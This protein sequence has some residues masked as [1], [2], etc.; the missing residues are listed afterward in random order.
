MCR[1]ERYYRMPRLRITKSDSSIANAS[2]HSDEVLYD[3]ERTRVFRSHLPDG[4]GTIICK[5]LLGP[6]ALQRL[7]HERKILERLGNI[8]GV[9]HL[10]PVQPVDSIALPDTRFTP[11]AEVVRYERMD[12]HVLLRGALHLTETIAAM[13][14]AGV[15]HKDINPTNILFSDADARFVLID[16]DLATTFLEE[17]PGFVPANEIAGTLAYLSPEQ[18]GRTGRSVDPRTDLYSLGVTLYQLATGQLPFEHDDPLQLIHDHLARTPVAPENYRELHIPPGLSDII[19]RLMEKEPDQRYQSAE[20]LAHD[21]ARLDGLLRQGASTRFALGERDFPLR[22]SPP[23]HLVGRDA[24][25]TALENAFN[26]T[27]RGSNSVLVTGAPGVGKSALTNELRTL[28]ATRGGWFVSGKFDQYRSDAGSGAVTQAFDALGQ[29]LLAEP[30]VRLTAERER[31]LQALGPNAGLIAAT[32]PTFALVLGIE[33]N[34]VVDDAASIGPRIACAALDALCAISSP[35]RPLVMVLDDLQW[36][37]AG[38]LGFIDAVLT[39]K[40][41]RDLLLVGTYRDTEVDATHPLTAMLARWQ[42]LNVAPQILQLANL[43]QNDLSTLLGEMLRLPPTESGQ[44]ARAIA[45]RTGGNPYDTVEL[46]NALRR[47]GVLIAG[48][49][50]W[51]W[52]DTNIQQH[53]GQGEVIDLLEVR[54]ARLPCE[55][56]ALLVVM[57]CLGGEVKLDLLQA[58]SG[59]GSAALEEHMT[60]AL[61]DGLLVM[62]RQGSVLRFRHDRVQQAAHTGL[63]AGRGRDLRFVLARRLALLPAFAVNAAELYLA[64]VDEIVD[65]AERRRAIELFEATA[66]QARLIADHATAERYLAAALTLLTRI[67]TTTDEPLFIRMETARHAAL[68]SLGRLAEADAI[69]CSLENRCRDPL[70]LAEAISLQVC[71]LTNRGQP[72]DAVNLGLALLKQLGLDVPNEDAFGVSVARQLEEFYAWADVDLDAET[73]QR[74][75]TSDRRV[76]AIVGLINKLMPPT[77]FCDHT[78][79]AWLFFETRRLWSSAGPSAA[80]IGILSHAVFVTVGAR[81]DYRTGYRLMQH[82]LAVG[83][84]LGYGVELSQGRFLSALCGHLF[85]P[86]EE[87]IRQAQLAREGLLA[88]GDIQNACFTYYASIPAVFECA[89]TL[90]AFGAEVE[91][92]LA[93]SARTGNDQTTEAFV[94]YRQ[95]LRAL[96]GETA[97]PGSLNDAVFDED[98]HLAVIA[99]NPAAGANFHEA[100][101]LA[102]MIFGDLDSLTKHAA[103]ALPLLKYTETTCATLL[104]H[105]LQGLALA[106]RAQVAAPPE[107]AALLKELDTCRDWLAE[108]ATDASSFPQLLHWLAA[109]RA[110]ANGDVLDAIA[111]FDAAII[112][113]ESKQRICQRALIVERAAL[114]H[115]THGT[116]HLGRTLMIQARHHYHG[117]GAAGKVRQLE[118]RYGFV[119]SIPD[120]RRKMESSSSSSGV[121]SDGIDLLGVL[122]ASQ[123]LSSETDLARLKD[124]VIELMGTLTGATQVQ[125]VLWQDEP[126]GWF[127][128]STAD[129]AATPIEEASTRNLLPLSVFRYVERTRNALLLDDA[130]RDDRF[131]RDAYFNGIEHCSLLAIPILSQGVTCAV[132]VMENRLSRSAFPAS[133]LEVVKLIAGQL[134]VSIDNARLYDSLERKV[135]QRT[136]ALNAANLRLETLSITDPLT[137]LANRRRFDELIQAEWQRAIRPKT[138]L[139]VAMVDIDQFKLYNDHYGHLGGDQCLQRVATALGQSVR[140]TDLVARYGGEEFVLIMPATDEAGA[141]IVAQRARAAVEALRTPHIKSTTGIVTIS[142]GVAATVP[143]TDTIPDQLIESADAALYDAKKSGRNRVV[144]A[145]S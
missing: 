40:R 131:C 117:W 118:Q 44:L 120:R 52:N 90:T 88:S 31:L 1:S 46:V 95:L 106:Q 101:A 19:L 127:L 80:M 65:T 110:W 5:Q 112:A 43:P 121:T 128:L 73:V 139:A 129:T 67:A 74:S 54:I 13:H 63:D 21:L 130:L 34:A 38:A 53:V 70:D 32:H 26:Q 48:D 91:S 36:A 61:E 37:D 8:A 86:L 24:E 45:A 72:R 126:E 28:V 87:S 66:I 14:R 76:L 89:P 71:S 133:R 10:L 134:A 59:L 2:R 123:L 69:Y 25:R 56:Q 111:S 141:C 60:P 103:A 125:L 82:V 16:F 3:S 132:L 47:E 58:A 18:T 144:E 50:G 57:A 140:D 55:S 84:A 98:A 17:R 136:E 137:G 30:E 11:L 49:T 145:K 79:I 135:A 22:L 4:S 115:L 138:S 9:Q 107:R 122:R 39:D 92:A 33:P 104:E 113:V 6:N 93:L 23:S 27:S 41:L 68:Y 94:G 35:T 102:A 109:E 42:R 51:T 119:H 81:Q 96:R 97:T 78:I 99:A 29:L 15:I 62:E 77:F 114:F 143:T 85:Q 108:R 105:L 12:M 124:R 100:G 7:R 83:E 116:E 64:T 75:P 20:G 142:V